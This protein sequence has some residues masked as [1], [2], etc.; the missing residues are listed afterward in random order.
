MPGLLA[1]P[2]CQGHSSAAQG[3]RK[4][5]ERARRKHD[6]LRATAWAVVDCIEVTQPRAVIVENVPTFRRWSKYDLWKQAIERDGYVVSERVIRATACGV[7]QRRDRLF[8][9]A[10]RKPINIGLPTWDGPEPAIADVIR[11]N[12]GRWRPVSSASPRARER[13]ERAR[14]NHGP[15]CLSQHVTGHP[16]IPTHEAIRTVTTK[17]Q[18][19]VVDGDVYRPLTIGETFA[20]MGFPPDYKLPD[21]ITRG[22]ALKMGG[23]AVAPPVG[24]WLVERVAEAA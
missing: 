16:G 12:E 13:I 22:T 24:R 3:A 21:G 14:R 4:F 10:T 11:W 7:P 6:A 17:D 23:N 2:A 8:I 19:V 18:W 1:A 5:N 20:A 9:T 15:R